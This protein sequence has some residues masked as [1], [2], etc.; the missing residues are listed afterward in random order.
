[1]ELLFKHKKLSS[2]RLTGDYIV[3]ALETGVQRYLSL[4]AAQLYPIS[5]VISSSRHTLYYSLLHRNQYAWT[6]TALTPATILS[7]SLRTDNPH[8]SFNKY[9][10]PIPDAHGTRALERGAGIL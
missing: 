10:R 1:M 4:A 9:I 5:S 8:K 6:I 3:P 2:T 7:S